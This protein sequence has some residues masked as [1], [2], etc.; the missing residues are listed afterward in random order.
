MHRLKNYL[1][2]EFSQAILTVLR[3]ITNMRATASEFKV[4]KA[5]AGLRYRGG[6]PLFCPSGNQRSRSLQQCHRAPFSLEDQLA[7]FSVHS[8]HIAATGP[9]KLCGNRLVGR[10]DL[11]ATHQDSPL[12]IEKNELRTADSTGAIKRIP[13]RRLPLSEAYRARYQ[14]C[15]AGH[16]GA[17]RASGQSP[18]CAYCHQRNK[19]DYCQQWL[20]SFHGSS[21]YELLLRN[22]QCVL[23]VNV[24]LTIYPS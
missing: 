13:S 9:L 21:C 11:A 10:Y 16:I 3:T 14:T 7:A 18:D 24:F 4:I 22:S 20:S 2:I 1:I 17:L 23:C 6:S 15:R 5:R 19:H 8:N 12:A